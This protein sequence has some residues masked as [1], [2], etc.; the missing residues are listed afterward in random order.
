MSIII[1]NRDKY[2]KPPLV[3]MGE[4]PHILEWLRSNWA[5]KIEIFLLKGTVEYFAN[6][7]HCDKNYHEF[8]NILTLP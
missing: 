1:N 3:V 4:G 5:T 8:S 6:Y 7:N 2:H